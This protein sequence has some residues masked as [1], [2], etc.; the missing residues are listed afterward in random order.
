MVRIFSQIL[1]LGL[2]LA[3]G[4][5]GDRDLGERFQS[6]QVVRLAGI[7]G[8][9]VGDVTPEG[10]G[11][12]ATAK[13]TM[14]I[15]RARFGFDPFQS[16]VVITGDVATDGHMEGTMV[17]TGAEKQVSSISFKGQAKSGSAESEAITG[18]LASGSCRWSVLLRRG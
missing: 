8:R 14:S 3:V 16:T 12:G 11:C 1:P 6:G 4:A 2:I 18:E 13:G 7:E 5:C 15:G 9:W 10:P 17:R